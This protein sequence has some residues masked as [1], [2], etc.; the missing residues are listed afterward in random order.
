MCLTFKMY[1]YVAHFA[2][3]RSLYLTPQ[4]AETNYLQRVFTIYK[5]TTSALI[6]K[7][8]TNNGIRYI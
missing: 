6:I 1:N 5:Q 8:M 7:N 4:S 3:E 2:P